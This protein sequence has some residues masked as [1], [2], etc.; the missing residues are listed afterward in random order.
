M[1]C[2]K[3][4]IDCFK[5]YNKIERI[6]IPSDFIICSLRK[7]SYIFKGSKIGKMKDSNLPIFSSI[8][9]K[10]I[11]YEK[12]NILNNKE[13]NCIVIENDYK[14]RIE[15]GIHRLSKINKEDFLTL[16]QKNGI[17]ELDGNCLPLYSKYNN[18]KISTLIIDSTINSFIIE[19]HCE[20]ILETID[21][22]LEANSINKATIII[23]KKDKKISKI[24]NN[25]IGTYL[26]IKVE[27][28]S[29]ELDYNI[30][31]DIIVN[32]ISTIYT[33]YQALKLNKPMI[34]K[35]ITISYNN[36]S[37]NLLVKLG[38]S[39]KEIINDIKYTLIIINNNFILKDIDNLIITPNINNIEIK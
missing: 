37:Y 17:V 6:Y 12:K 27:T 38:T 30:K 1:N 2:L 14:E 20:Q 21:M 34:E 26:N 28:I 24:I 31:N 35:Y 8:S 25:Y 11:G 3:G 36:S 5:N 22:I 29:K 18:T 10:V 13:F 19:N 39:L 33:V 7:D 4:K 32:N 9:G 16:L 15:K 23:S